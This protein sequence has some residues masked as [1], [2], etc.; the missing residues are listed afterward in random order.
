MLPEIWSTLSQDLVSEG[1]V[2]GWLKIK[3]RCTRYIMCGELPKKMH[4][5]SKTKKDS[6]CDF[7]P[8]NDS[9]KLNNELNV[10]APVFVPALAQCA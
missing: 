1:R 10:S 2:R 3:S 6:K 4:R 8:E 7:I 9:T 5:K